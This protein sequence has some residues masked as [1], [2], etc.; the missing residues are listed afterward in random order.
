MAAPNTVS[1]LWALAQTTADVLGVSRGILEAATTDNVQA[2]ALLACEAFGATLPMSTES[3]SKAHLLCSRDHTSSTLNFLKAKI[4]YSRGDSGWQLARSDAGLRFLGLAA[5]M[6]SQD[7]WISAEM[8]RGLITETAEDRKLVPTAHQIKSLLGVLE[9][10][11]AKAGFA[12]NVL[13]WGLWLDEILGKQTISVSHPSPAVFSKMITSISTLARLGEDTGKYHFL[14]LRIPH[15]QAAWTIAF[16]KW[17]L[18]SPPTVVKENG[19]M[20]L[21]QT[22]CQ[23]YVYPL[24]DVKNDDV[25]LSIWDEVGSMK[26]LFKGL[27]D[28]LG[29]IQGMI[30]VRRFAEKLLQ[31][32][33]ATGSVQQRAALE[34]LPYACHEAYALLTVGRDREHTIHNIN[35]MKRVLKNKHPHIEVVEGNVFPTRETV[36]IAMAQ[37]LGKEGQ[38]QFKEPPYELTV[39]RLPSALAAKQILCSNCPCHTCLATAP[40]TR[41]KCEFEIWLRHISKCIS[42]ILLVSLIVPVDPDGVLLRYRFSAP[43]ISDNFTT[44]IY[45]CL[46]GNSDTYC[47]VGDVIDQAMYLVGHDELV[48][49]PGAWIVSS[50]N[51]QT[52]YPEVLQSLKVEPVGL[53]TLICVPGSLTWNDET[54]HLVEKAAALLYESDASD[55]SLEETIQLPRHG[56]VDSRLPPNYIP[57][58]AYPSAKLMWRVSASEN[59]L[60]LTIV[61]R[62]LPDLP[63]RSSL[64]SIYT[65]AK[66]VFVNCKHD[67][68]G[69][70]TD[71]DEF[72]LILGTPS[73]PI[74][75]GQSEFDLA[76]VQTDG[77][78]AMRYFTL[79][80]K[81]KCTIRS[82]ACLQCCIEVARVWNFSY[83]L[84]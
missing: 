81:I 24:A 16:L 13:G 29:S 46:I 28:G 6:L 11:L 67:V 31:R 59:S 25:E 56:D 79:C 9:Y 8:L 68:Y 23:A 77:N 2:L 66:S 44:A 76:I 10:R 15:A 69:A 32:T 30:S 42:A 61:A 12:D 63:E 4:G 83:I 34:M 58:D 75:S 52:L 78:D 53:L 1:L 39:D 55:S 37:F 40:Q 17:C 26:Q 54:Y 84:C 7:H 73:K 65:A 74:I 70:L 20:L 49:G 62:N 47:G 48:N 64:S 5:C 38:V 71:E 14:R 43:G 41:R 57:E 82:Q 50:E 51:G 19:T 22:D 72:H 45:H 80:S 27:R 21:S 60:K 3:K 18:G 36:M 35:L 33:G